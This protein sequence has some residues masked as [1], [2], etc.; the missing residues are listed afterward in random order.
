[1][2]VG[3]EGGAQPRDRAQ[4]RQAGKLLI[5]VFERK[6]DVHAMVGDGRYAGVEPAFEIDDDVD[7]SP[8]DRFPV[9]Q[10]RGNEQPAVVV[11]LKKVHRCGSSLPEPS[12]SPST[13][14]VDGV[15]THSY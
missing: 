5:V 6:I 14:S 4:L 2:A 13:A 7:P 3:D 1:M 15:R 11:D 9:V 10:R 8:R 12:A